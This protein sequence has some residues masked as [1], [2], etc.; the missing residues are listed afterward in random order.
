MGPLL[1]ANSWCPLPQG[2]RQVDRGGVQRPRIPAAGEG[3][4]RRGTGC[5]RAGGFRLSDPTEGQLCALGRAPGLFT[6]FAHL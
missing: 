4:D 6:Q 5:N 3:V 2:C 1:R